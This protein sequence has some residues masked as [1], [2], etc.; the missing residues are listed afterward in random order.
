MPEQGPC[1]TIKTDAWR[2]FGATLTLKQVSSNCMIAIE[3]D[4]F[5]KVILRSVLHVVDSPEL[6]VL[7]TRRM[8]Q[9]DPQYERTV[10]F[11]ECAYG[12]ASSG[13]ELVIP[14]NSNTGSPPALVFMYELVYKKDFEEI[15]DSIWGGTMRARRRELA[16]KKAARKIWEFLDWYIN[17]SDRYRMAHNDLHCQNV[18]I[19]TRRDTL[20]L[21]DFG[22]V[23]FG[24]NWDDDDTLQNICKFTGRQFTY[25]QLMQNLERRVPGGI[26]RPPVLGA[27]WLG[28]IMRLLTDVLMDNLS[29]YILYPIILPG[30]VTISPPNPPTHTYATCEFRVWETDSAMDIADRVLSDVARQSIRFGQQSWTPLSA[31]E[32]D[33]LSPL[34]LIASVGLTCLTIVC[35]RL[36]KVLGLKGGP[37]TQS[38]SRARLSTDRHIVET[39]DR[40]VTKGPDPGD[41]YTYEMDGD[42][43]YD[44]CKYGVHFL[45]TPSDVQ[46]ARRV[47]LDV[48]ANQIQTQT[49]TQTQTAG[50]SAA[51]AARDDGE[52]E[53]ENDHLQILSKLFPATLEDAYASRSHR[54]VS[55][56]NRKASSTGRASDTPSSLSSLATSAWSLTS[57][58]SARKAVMVHGG[59]GGGGEGGSRSSRMFIVPAIAV[60]LTI[61]ASL[62]SVARF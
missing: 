3:G 43:I 30:N 14:W 16:S 54:Q 55:R 19:D 61:A 29:C 1:A 60:S 46:A 58:P 56:G 57:S 36:V 40:I 28:D 23:T 31:T 8:A 52:G 38:M 62:F 26:H 24:T 44:L 20:R 34:C 7:N 15:P 47:V 50:A 11:C 49:Q 45:L 2:R 4:T 27:P 21:I 33:A 22:R 10:Q 13:S 18:I 48:I 42:D 59:G 6:D 37:Q 32:L 9:I 41:P 51:N 39:F 35:M 53:N 17:V 25:A 5:F 12:D